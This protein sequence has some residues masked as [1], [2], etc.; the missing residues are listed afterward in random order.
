RSM[1]RATM[2][3]K[4][5][6]SRTSSSTA[7][8]LPPAPLI[9]AAT[10][11]ASSSWRSARTTCAPPRPSS[12]PSAAPMPE[13]PPVTIATASWNERMVLVPSSDMRRSLTPK[14]LDAEARLRQALST[15]MTTYRQFVLASRPEGEVKPENFRLETVAVPAMKEGEVLVRNHYLSLD[16]YMRGRMDDVRSYAPPQPLGE[17]MV[18]GTAGEVI[19]SLSPALK[20]G[21]KVVGMLGW[22]EMGVSNARALHKV[23]TTEV[24]LSAY[25]GP[26]G[27]PGI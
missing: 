3:S 19:E 27:M 24:P 12:R 23:D 25:L 2:A 6:A 8:P 10:S 9:E 15:S 7:S 1:V 14:G 11:L 20:A 18:G 4:A 26:A 16:P 13:A 5:M 21:D 17:V 22:A